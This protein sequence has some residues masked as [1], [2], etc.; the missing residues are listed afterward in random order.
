MSLS[1]GCK[2]SIWAIRWMNESRLCQDKGPII[3]FGDNNGSISLT[4]NPENHSRTKHIEVQYHFVREK[5]QEGLVRVEYV[6]TKDQLADILT[7]PLSNS[8]S[9][10]IG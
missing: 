5:V 1:E 7:K 6:S 2:A 8:L 10:P 4:K 3:L 9:K